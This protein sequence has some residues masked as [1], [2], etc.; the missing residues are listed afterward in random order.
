VGGRLGELLERRKFGKPGGRG[1]QCKRVLIN[2]GWENLESL[3]T[4]EAS[5][6][7]HY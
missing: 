2:R 5:K 7:G 3:D 4:V 6:K 1:G